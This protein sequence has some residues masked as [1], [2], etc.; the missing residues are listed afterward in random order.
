MK[1]LTRDEM[2]KVMGGYA[3]GGDSGDGTSCNSDA[4]CPSTPKT[5]TCSDGTT[6]QAAWH[7][8]VTKVCTHGGC[9]Y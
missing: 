5:V 1:Q 7:C 4:D 3:P 8:S 6:F 9:A 2:K